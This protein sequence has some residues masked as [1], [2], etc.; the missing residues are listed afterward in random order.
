MVINKLPVMPQ[1]LRGSTLVDNLIL[2]LV[3]TIITFILYSPWVIERIGAWL[4]SALGLSTTDS[5]PWWWIV[6]TILV[7][8]GL[9]AYI[10]IQW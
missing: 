2:S 8:V 7:N 4:K 10:L 9:F 3:F 1:V 6:L 5:I